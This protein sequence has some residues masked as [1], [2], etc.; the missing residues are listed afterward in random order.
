MAGLIR[1]D[2]DRMRHPR[3]SLIVSGRQW[4]LDQLDAEFC[5]RRH[6]LGQMALTPAFV[7][8]DDQPRRRRGAAHRAY[9]FDVAVAG[10][11]QLQQWPSAL[12]RRGLTHALGGIQAQRIGGH[13]RS[14]RADAREIGSPAVVALGVEIPEGRIQ[15][16]SRRAGRHC[17]LQFLAVEPGKNCA[18]HVL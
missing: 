5:E 10:Q 7:G 3:Q 2:R 18:A 8:I 14:Q 11:L 13:Q 15:R 16:V 4:L 1:A 17:L 12:R 6:H 9:P